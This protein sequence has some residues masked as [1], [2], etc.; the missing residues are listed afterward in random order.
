MK[1]KE[2]ICPLCQNDFKQQEEKVGTYLFLK[3]TDAKWSGIFRITQW[4]W[5]RYFLDGRIGY[6]PTALS[7]VKIMPDSNEGSGTD[8][9]NF[10]IC[11]DCIEKHITHNA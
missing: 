2:N 10:Q 11:P 4:P 6:F 1:I 3:L 5:C 7:L 8:N 9:P